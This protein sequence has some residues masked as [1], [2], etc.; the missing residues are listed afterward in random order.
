MQH[1]QSV[2]TD[3]RGLEPGGKIW[4]LR[5]EAAG[6]VIEIESPGLGLEVAGRKIAFA[7]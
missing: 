4:E 3:K 1:P 5:A 6:K 7:Y 2:L